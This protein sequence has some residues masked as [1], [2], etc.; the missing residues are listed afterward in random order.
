[1]NNIITNERIKE[2]QTKIDS[3][4]VGVKFQLKKEQTKPEYKTFYVYAKSDLLDWSGNLVCEENDRVALT[5]MDLDNGF[6]SIDIK[7]NH[8]S[9]FFTKATKEEI[10]KLVSSKK[11]AQSMDCYIGS[12]F[13]TVCV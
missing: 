8:N 7:G 1:M 11:P 13:Y 2:L 5:V 10:S 9:F 3:I 12:E 6:Y 4:T